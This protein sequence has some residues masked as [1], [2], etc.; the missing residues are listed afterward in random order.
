MSARW[1]CKV[2]RT[3]GLGGPDGWLKHQKS[4]HT[5]GHRYGASTSIVGGPNFGIGRRVSNSRFGF[6][7]APRLGDE[8]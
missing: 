3:Y 7:P 8:S 5:D 6:V 4:E 2:C 1:H